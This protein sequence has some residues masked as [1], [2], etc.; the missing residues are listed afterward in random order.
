[1]TFKTIICLT[2]SLVCDYSFASGMYWANQQQDSGN[3]VLFI[4]GA[5]GTLSGDA[6]QVVASGGNCSTVTAVP[7]SHYHFVNWTRVGSAYSTSNPLTVSGVASNMTL[8]ANFSIDAY[9]VSFSSAG[10][11]SLS[12]T[13]TQTV[14]Y[15]S[16]CSSITAVPDTGYLFDEWSGSISG[17]SNPLTVNNVTSAMTITANFI[18][19]YTVTFTEVS[20]GTFVGE[21]TQIVPTGGN[22]SEVSITPWTGYRF[23]QWVWNLQQY[24]TSN[25]LTVTNVDTDMTIYS[26]LSNVYMIT[27]ELE[28]PGAG[29][30]SGTGTS[31]NQQS[32]SQA[33]VYNH[34]S[35][36][37]LIHNNSGWYFSKWWNDTDNVEIE[38]GSDPKSLIVHSVTKDLHITARF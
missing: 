38:G 34:D 6:L 21:Q 30:F 10:N 37:I 17:S 27:V 31:L 5:H 18:R 29:W 20:G 11:G 35:T 23:Q 14:N 15:G 36:E 22:C 25:P 26:Y 32:V 12:G 1:M 13:V 8:T 16:S 19:A 4:P 7:D 33:V 24:S 2:M 3:V 28:A 9:S